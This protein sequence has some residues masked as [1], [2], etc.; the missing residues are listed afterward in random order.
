MKVQLKQVGGSGAAAGE[1][2]VFEGGLWTPGIAP[3]ALR[4]LVGP[5]GSGAPYSSV[6]AAITAAVADGATSSAPLGVFVL[7]G[8][9]T[10]N[11]ALSPGIALSGLGGR[12]AT[13]RAKIVGSMTYAGSAGNGNASIRNLYLEGN[14]SGC[15][16]VTGTEV[17]V[18]ELQGVIC[19]QPVNAELD[20]VRLNAGSTLLYAEGCDFLS[21][22]GIAEDSFLSYGLNVLAGEA[23]LKF[24]SLR[25]N[26]DSP[27][28]GFPL[29]PEAIGTELLKIGSASL[30]SLFCCKLNGHVEVLATGE[31]RA[32]QSEFG[33]VDNEGIVVF[34][35][36]S[37]AHH[38]VG[39]GTCDYGMIE[40]T[41]DPSLSSGSALPYPC[42]V[43][44]VNPVSLVSSASEPVGTETKVV[45]VTPAAGGT[46]ITLPTPAGS[47][48]GQTIIIADAAGNAATNNITVD[49]N[50]SLILGASTLVL[51]ANYQ[52]VTLCFDGTVW[53]VI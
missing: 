48:V 40:W 15:L 19:E 23:S 2:P 52:S 45:S 35:G 10:E 42:V 29:P 31:M 41:G 1:V 6:Q 30:V 34:H 36:A 11:V 26:T 18:L 9:Y 17:S 49:G 38:M 5:A 8:T 46:T 37:V 22:G 51:N 44:V 33:I 16:T 12:L 32:D 3:G 47:F 43:N 24:C 4:Y 21:F 53:L 39:S 25:G 28:I 7:P 13:T 20:A 27:T 50:G 14:S